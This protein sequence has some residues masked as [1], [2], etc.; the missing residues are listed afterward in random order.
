MY[1]AV[2][3]DQER[4]RECERGERKGKVDV[5]PIIMCCPFQWRVHVHTFSKHSHSLGCLPCPPGSADGMIIALR[6]R[7]VH[8]MWRGQRQ[9]KGHCV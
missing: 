6:V 4:K 2:V 7:N 9:V 8:D 5:N 1:K 3:G